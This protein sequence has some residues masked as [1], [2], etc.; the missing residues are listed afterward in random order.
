[1]MKKAL[2]P[3]IFGVETTQLTEREVALFAQH[4][5]LGYI[6][7]ARNIETPAQLSGLVTQLREIH[8]DY[9]PLMLIDQE[10]GRVARLRSPY[11]ETPPPAQHYA[12]L[13]E[14]E[15]LDAAKEAAYAGSA[16]IARSL[17]AL[18]INVN[19]APMCDVRFADSHEIIGDRAY[20]AQPTQVIALAESVAQGLLDHG[21]LPV[22]KHIPGHGRALVDSHESLPIVEASRAELEVDFAPFKALA[23]LPL[24]MTAHIIYTALDAH[25]PATLSPTVIR[26][27]REEIGFHGLLMSDDV[28][29]KALHAPMGTLAVDALRA[30]CDAVLHCNGAFDEMQ[31][32]CSALML[33]QMAIS[34][35]TLQHLYEKIAQKKCAL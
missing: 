32:I 18:G 11:W 25:L 2:L 22:I 7:F 33:Q 20:G 9:T 3:V 26:V 10:G 21:V 19:C 13:T 23:H 15:G 27:I 30:G 28:C 16:A 1:M 5:P 14:I 12:Q 24:A 34:C 17:V 8:T 29:M 31:E 6:F 35:E 4:R